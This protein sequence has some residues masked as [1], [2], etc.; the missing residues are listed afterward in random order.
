MIILL[1]Y[2]QN[3]LQALLQGNKYVSVKSSELEVLY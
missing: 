1:F 2:F 3:C